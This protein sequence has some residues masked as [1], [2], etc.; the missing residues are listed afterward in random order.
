V[1][2]VGTQLTGANVGDS[3]LYLFDREGETRI[4]TEN[5]KRLGSGHAQAFIRSGAS[6]TLKPGESSNGD[7]DVSKYYD[8]TTPGEYTVQL[9]TPQ[10]PEIKGEFKSNVL[11]VTVT[12]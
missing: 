12:P 3:R 8:L 1:A 5:T 7:F 11:T 6:F 10:I 2:S 9:I 4:L